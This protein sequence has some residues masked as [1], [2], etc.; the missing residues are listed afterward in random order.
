MYYTVDVMLISISEWGFIMQPFA[1]KEKE[2]ERLICDHAKTKTNSNA[3]TTKETKKHGLKSET[4]LH[5]SGPRIYLSGWSS[6]PPVCRS[7]SAGHGR[8]PIP[9]R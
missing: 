2:N 5:M 7:F 1:E 8:G 9:R 3:K 6:R 4:S